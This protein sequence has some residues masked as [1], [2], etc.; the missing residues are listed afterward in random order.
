MDNRDAITYLQN[1]PDVTQGRRNVAYQRSVSREEVDV[2]IGE[3]DFL[4][5]MEGEGWGR[6]G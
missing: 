2:R 3:A 6:D 1:R 5:G 4:F